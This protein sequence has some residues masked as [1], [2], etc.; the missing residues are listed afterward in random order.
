MPI[1]RGHLGGLASVCAEF[2][3]NMGQPRTWGVVWVWV[4][5]CRAS[6]CIRI[7]MIVIYDA[8]GVDTSDGRRPLPARPIMPV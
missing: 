1:W 4:A 8:D 5:G 6:A 7:W 3:A 2:A